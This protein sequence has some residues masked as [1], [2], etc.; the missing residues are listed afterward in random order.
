MMAAIRF[1][2]QENVIASDFDRGIRFISKDKFEELAAYVVRPGDILVTMMGTSGRCATA[3]ATLQLGIMDSHLLRIRVGET[4]DSEFLRLLIDEAPYV[5]HQVEA[6][7]KGSI[8]HGLNSGVIRDL[9]VALPPV[10]EQLAISRFADREAAKI[11]A[12]IEEQR[13]LIELLK[14]K[15]QAVISHAV[16]KGLNSSAATKPSGVAWVGDIPAHWDVVRSRR[17]FRVRNEPARDSD[18]QLTASQKY[19]MVFQAHFIEME[20]RRVVEVIQGTDSLRHAERNDFVI[21]LRSFQGGLEWCKFAG[22]VTFHYVILVPVKDVHEPFFAHLFKSVS[23]IQA[24]RST[25]NLI[26]DGQDL[27]YSHFAL[28]DL[29]KIPIEE[30]AQIASYLDRETARIDSLNSEVQ[31]TIERLKER[32]SALVSAAV[33]GKID[34]RNYVP[35]ESSV[36]EAVYEPA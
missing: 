1:Y 23:Y 27:R 29:P 20:G 31:L 34:V 32:R 21:S 11:D 7:G 22:S 33:T 4:I 2:G 25:A 17:L 10:S 15:R 8:M 36:S 5:S 35:S 12:L 13:R 14:E 24:L 28:V 26:R 18:R 6:L 16:T 3:P 9:V 30:Q 19:G